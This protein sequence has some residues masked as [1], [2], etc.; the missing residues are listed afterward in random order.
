[1]HR[2][3]I[4][5]HEF[6]ARFEAC[7]LSA[8]DFNHRAHV[9]IAY[10]YLS[11]GEPAQAY[12]RMRKSLLRFLAFHEVDPAKYHE[13]M[14]HAWLLAVRYFMTLCPESDSADAFI[15]AD[16]RLLDPKIMATH[17]SAERLFSDEA[18]TA[19]VAPDLDPIPGLVEARGT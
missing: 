3:S 1:M 15:A 17:Y 6:R 8:A 13:T 7:E 9:R 11:E 18:R 2:P 5:D 14:T 4:A 12:A 19:F 10:I 16:P